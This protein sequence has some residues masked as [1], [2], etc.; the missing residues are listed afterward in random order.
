VIPNE[1]QSPS[2]IEDV[3]GSDRMGSLSHVPTSAEDFHGDGMDGE[4]DVVFSDSLLR[5]RGVTPA[6][7]FIKN[8]SLSAG[9]NAPGLL[10]PDGHSNLPL[11]GPGDAAHGIVGCSGLGKPLGAGH[12]ASPNLASV[13]VASDWTA[14]LDE[15]SADH[16]AAHS[17]TFAEAVLALTGRVL[18]ND[19]N[20]GDYDVSARWDAPAVPFSV[21]SRGAYASRGDDLRL[22][23]AG[24]VELDRVVKV[25]RV[26]WSGHVYNLTSSE[27]WF[28]AN[29][30]IVS[31]CDCRHIPSA[32]SMA[33]DFTTDPY[34]YFN[35]LTPEE[36]DKLF[37]PHG[38]S[39]ERAAQVGISNARG[40]RAGGDIYRVENIR[41]RGVGTSKAKKIYGTPQVTLD[42]IYR[43]A[44]NRSGAIRLMTEHGYITGPQV[45]GGNILGNL[46]TDAKI[47]A[48]GRG[49]G[50][51]SM[52]GS[53]LKT[54]RAKVFDSV[55]S[56]VRNPL[57]RVTLTAAE[58]RM[59]DAKY[60]YEV[61]LSGTFPRSVG[62]SSSDKFVRSRAPSAAELAA[63]ERDFVKEAAI[64]QRSMPKFD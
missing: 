54:N 29:S 52:D 23:L 14:S 59:F 40:I 19:G 36:Q 53:Q 49:K 5:D 38:V 60:K 27:G 21:E 45:A 11:G 63:F 3:W 43:V 6:G 16:I 39:R 12:F 25:E 35:S 7:E 10:A 46:N 56:G 22:R 44:G 4:V 1:Q 20:D 57:D 62:R 15:A 50:T 34:A 58:R 61:A 37:R 9:V 51:F 8:E 42:D 30:L 31:N 64:V 55:E 2:L 41:L 28:T 26:Q 13:G 24:Q 47:L 18:R 33:G 17:V 32:E 48:R